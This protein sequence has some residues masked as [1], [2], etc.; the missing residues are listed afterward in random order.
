MKTTTSLFFL[1]LLYCCAQGQAFSVN[2]G[3]DEHLCDTTSPCVTLNPSIFGGSGPFTYLWSPSTGLNNNSIQNPCARPALTTDYILTVS[4]GT[5]FAQD[6]ITV[7]VEPIPTLDAGSAVEICPGDSVQLDASLSFG[8]AGPS[9][10]TTFTY[11]WSPTAGLSSPTVEDPMASPSSTTFYQV[12]ALSNWGCASLVDSVLVS[13]VPLQTPTVSQSNDSLIA[14]DP[15]GFASLQWFQDG[16]PIAGATDAWYVPDTSACYSVQA[17]IGPCQAISDTI[18]PVLVALPEILEGMAFEMGPHP[19][20]DHLTLHLKLE[21]SETIG[22]AWT[23]VYGRKLKVR[24]PK[25]LS[26]GGQIIE[27]TA[28]DLPEA[29]GVYSLHLRHGNQEMVRRVLRLAE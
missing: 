12:F 5:Q 8:G 25:R 19:V 15:S 3:P 17:S 24:E 6:T 14:T 4:N 10:G 2:A 13:V 23:D 16:M 1:L 7:Y 11:A 26:P 29:S 22:I 27:L 21:K 18:C 9:V 28:E 20:V